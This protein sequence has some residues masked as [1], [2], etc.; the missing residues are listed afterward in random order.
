LSRSQT[1]YP[2]RAINLQI[3]FPPGTGNDLLGRALANKLPAY[4]G[5]TVVV[6]NRAGASGYIATEY[7]RKATPDGHTLVLASVSFSIVPA[8]TNLRYTADEFT[9]IAMLGSLPFVL[10]L[11]KS[12][13]VSNMAGLIDYV[14]KQPNK[15]SIGQGG[16]TGTTYFLVESLK[17][18]SSIEVVSVPY[19]GTTDAIRDLLAGH[20]DMMF[21]PISTGLSYHRTNDV[22][23]LGITGTERTTLVPELAT[24]SEQGYP[25]LD[26]TTW[27]ALLGP[28][29]LSRNTVD[30]LSQAIE[31][32]LFDVQVIQALENLG[33]LPDYKNPATLKSFLQTDAQRWSELVSSSGLRLK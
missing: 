27:F 16:P 31:K 28:A 5:Q 4:L 20:I 29:G 23:L 7:T 15:L 8:T 6:E 11:N 14:K 13:P 17:K 1:T 25:T 12:I 32:T 18:A 26:I 24:F 33:I 10:I 22:K 9:P 2:S 30:I 3:P 21:A 19:K